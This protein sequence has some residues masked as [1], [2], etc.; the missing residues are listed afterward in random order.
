MK[1][2]T[3]FAPKSLVD[4]APAQRAKEMDSGS[5]LS[6]KGLKL[7]ILLPSKVL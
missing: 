5:P 1:E 6:R 3:T 7:H 4:S 2:A